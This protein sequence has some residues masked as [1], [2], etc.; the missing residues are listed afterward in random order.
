MSNMNSLPRKHSKKK[1]NSGA[2]KGK[3]R[4]EGKIT[5]PLIALSELEPL[6][7]NGKSMKL[8]EFVKKFSNY[9]PIR[10]NVE[11]GYCGTE[12]RLV[13]G[14]SPFSSPS[15][16]SSSS[17]S[18]LLPFSY[19]YLLPTLFLL[20]LTPFFPLFL[21]SFL[22]SLSSSLY[23]LP[24]PLSLSPPPPSPSLPLLPLPPSLPPFF[25][26]NTYTPFKPMHLAT[27]IDLLPM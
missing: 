23:S 2:G 16:L 12:E 21:T 13:F 25:P 7:S 8:L 17:L 1:K 19:L 26:S 5:S 4:P 11:E 6:P 14:F 9:L 20:P 27:V 18:F 22:L 15:L 3:D 10:V 24:V